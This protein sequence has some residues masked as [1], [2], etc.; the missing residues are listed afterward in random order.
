MRCAEYESLSRNILD[1]DTC[2]LQLTGS[3]PPKGTYTQSPRYV[4]TYSGRQKGTTVPSVLLLTNM[5]SWSP[6]LSYFVMRTDQS[7]GVVYLFSDGGPP[8]GAK[9]Y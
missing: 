5:N 3:S 7:R 2:T 4:V 1:T 9:L 8:E 6:S